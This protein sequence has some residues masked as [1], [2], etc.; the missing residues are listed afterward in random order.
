MGVEQ[1]LFHAPPVCVIKFTLKQARDMFSLRVFSTNTWR[2]HGDAQ[3]AKMQNL[4]TNQRFLASWIIIRA[5]KGP[6]YSFNPDFD[7]KNVHEA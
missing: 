5:D 3:G 2:Q 4:A 6:T 7:V 1:K